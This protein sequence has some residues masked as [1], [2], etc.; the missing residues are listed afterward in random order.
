MIDLLPL[1]DVCLQLQ[2]L[3]E[4]H[5]RDMLV[6]RLYRLA[7]PVRDEQKAL[8]RK[9]GTGMDWLAI[10]E[11]HP[12]HEERERMW[13][14]WEKDYRAISDMLENARLAAAGTTPAQ[15]HPT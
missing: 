15:P 1:N 5:R 7:A 6:T 11:G 9:L 8:E 10:N 13:M 12:L 4:S 14:Q 2:G 3:G